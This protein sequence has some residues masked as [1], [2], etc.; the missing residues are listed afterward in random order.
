[1]RN[2]IHTGAGQ[3][4][5]S[6]PQLDEFADVLGKTFSGIPPD[7]DTGPLL[8]RAEPKCACARLKVNKTCD[9]N[10]LAAAPRQH[11]P[12][13]FLVALLRF[14]VFFSDPFFS[15]FW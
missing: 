4:Y 13:E 3:V 12:D 5:A 15:V 8:N 14:Y 9:E 10:G 1:M 2:I 7:R 11:V 6:Q